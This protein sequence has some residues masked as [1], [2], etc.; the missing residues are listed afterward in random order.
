M[1]ESQ[2]PIFMKEA[3]LYKWSGKHIYI[4]LTHLDVPLKRKWF[5]DSV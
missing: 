3:D 1:R 4:F 2:L 5:W